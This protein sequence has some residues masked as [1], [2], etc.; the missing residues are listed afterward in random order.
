MFTGIPLYYTF[1]KISNI[2]L[3]LMT[4]LR[5]YIKIYILLIIYSLVDCEKYSIMEKYLYIKCYMLSKW[6]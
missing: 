5:H 6:L 4:I 2:P 1:Y 3:L